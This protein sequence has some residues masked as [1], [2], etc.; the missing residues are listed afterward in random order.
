MKLGNSM[1][2]IFTK[3]KKN[4]FIGVYRFENN[5]FVAGK[6]LGIN[7]ENYIIL[8]SYNPYGKRDGFKLIALSI[9]KRLTVE[10]DYLKILEKKVERRQ[11]L[12]K[13][14]VLPQNKFS[15]KLFED[16]RGF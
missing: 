5:A 6:Y 1:K 4:Q 3:I 12:E 9:V 15:I 14:I 2:K 8:E 10:S 13:V 11:N 16:I 7:D